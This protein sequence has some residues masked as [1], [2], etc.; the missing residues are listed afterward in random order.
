MFIEFLVNEGEETDHALIR[1]DQIL[2]V[3]QVDDEYTHL[4]INVVVD[5][6]NTVWVK[7][8]YDVVKKKLTDN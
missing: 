4:I 3:L 1:K 8:P 2:R 6:S 7:E 5:E